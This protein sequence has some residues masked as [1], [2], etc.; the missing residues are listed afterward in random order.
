MQVSLNITCLLSL[1]LIF[2]HAVGNILKVHYKAMKCNG[3][4]LHGTVAYVGYLDEMDMFYK[5]VKIFF[6]ITVQKL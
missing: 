2:L 3:L 4:F 5:C 6:L 1:Y